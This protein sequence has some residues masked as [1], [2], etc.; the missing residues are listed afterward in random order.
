MCAA[1]CPDGGRRRVKA[2]FD[3]SSGFRRGILI[4]AIE[5][6]VGFDPEQPFRFV[7]SD[8]DKQTFADNSAGRHGPT[9]LRR[10]VTA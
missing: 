1:N 6:M 2:I 4:E 9:L 5:E 3:F 8:S 7:E 10:S